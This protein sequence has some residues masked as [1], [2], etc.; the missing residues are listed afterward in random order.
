MKLALLLHFY[1]PHNQQS[2]ILN[3]IVNESYLPIT[4]GLLARPHARLTVNISGAL[5]EL[6]TQNGYTEVIGNLKTLLDRGQIEIT[7]SA[8]YH[9]FLPLLPESEIDR[10]IVLNNESNSKY[11]GTS[12]SPKGFFTPELAVSQNILQIVKLK[13]FDW[14]GVPQV[15]KVGG[16]PDCAHLYKEKETGLNVFFRN[17]RVSSLI[18]SGVCRDAEDFIKETTDIHSQAYW[19]CVMDAETFGHHRVGHEKFLF[20]VLDNKFFEPVTVSDLLKE[21]LPAQEVELRPSTWTNE[22]QD[23][24]ID[25]EHI[26]ATSA[27]SFI[28]WQDPENPIHTLQWKLAILA[29]QSVQDFPNKTSENYLKARALLDM[30]ISSDQFWWA[31]AKPWW[32]LEMIEQGAYGLKAVLITLEPDSLSA[33]EA[34]VLYRAILDQAFDWQRSGYIRKKH[35]ENS[36]TYMKEPFNTRAPAEW[37]NQIILEFEDE[38]TRAATK[39]EFEKAIKWRDALIKLKNGTDIYDVL[40]VVDE[41]WAARNIPQLKPFVEHKPEELSKFSRDYFRPL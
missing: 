19:F 26:V 1:Q 6:L 30:A 35:L 28:L 27:R 11:L 18:L 22:E 25:R 4:R 33:K 34:E 16:D 21:N 40:H 29:M 39:R 13:G 14:I 12:Y 37:Y 36:G 3:R 31:S 8:K 2:D 20:D 15:S 24:W 5:L 9:A 32:S 23:F 17:K 38:M 10:Q 41:L 7:G